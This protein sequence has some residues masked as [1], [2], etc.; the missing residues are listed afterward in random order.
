MEEDMETSKPHPLT[1]SL[2]VPPIADSLTA[3]S[4]PPNI[5]CA[6]GRHDMKGCSREYK[7]ALRVIGGIRTFVKILAIPTA[8]CP[9]IRF[10]DTLT[11]ITC[12]VSINNRYVYL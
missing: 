9:I 7:E 4:L 3:F 11:S 12:D 5:K 8:R 2:P 10:T 6:G 1:L